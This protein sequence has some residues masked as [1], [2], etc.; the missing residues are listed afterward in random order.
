[1][2]RKKNT[3][4]RLGAQEREGQ[5]KERKEKESK[6]KKEKQEKKTTTF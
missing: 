3:P 5:K 4:T 2:Y 1:M 6:K